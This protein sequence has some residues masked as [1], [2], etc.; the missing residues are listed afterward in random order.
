[1]VRGPP[2][3]ET[4]AGKGWD[5][6]LEGHAGLRFYWNCPMGEKHLKY[7]VSLL[8]SS[9]PGNPTEEKGEGE[10]TGIRVTS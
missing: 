4:Q 5:Q 7:R 6:G 10:G 2:E 8:F 3:L 1:M 9:I